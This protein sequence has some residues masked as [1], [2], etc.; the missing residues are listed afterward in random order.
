MGGEHSEIEVRHV[1]ENQRFEVRREN[2]VAFLSY[3][4]DGDVVSFDH[5]YVPDSWR[6]RGVAAALVRAAVTEARARG[7]KVRP[8]CS[9]VVTFFQRNPELADVVR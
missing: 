1:P 2:D 9:Y 5:T 7:W 6:G 8:L 3:T 4:E